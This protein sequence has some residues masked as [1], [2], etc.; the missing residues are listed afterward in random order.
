VLTE[1]TQSGWYC[2]IGNV[3]FPH[4][5]HDYH[6]KWLEGLAKRTAGA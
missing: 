2:R 5:M 6:Q 4:R 1:E 3:I